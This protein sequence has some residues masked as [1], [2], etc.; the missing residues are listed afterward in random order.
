[1]NTY[2]SNVDIFNQ[3]LTLPERVFR[4]VNRC[5]IPPT[6]LGSLQFQYHPKTIVID[7]V[8]ILHKALFLRLENCQ[9]AQQ[10][11]EIFMNYMAVHFRLYQLEDAGWDKDNAQHRSKVDY[12]RML[13]GWL[14]DTNSREGAVLKCWV[15]SRFGLV[16]RFHHE[17]LKQEE[18]YHSFQQLGAQGLYGT[19]ALEAQLD[20]LY[21]YCQ[22][23]LA[24]RFTDNDSLC[25]YRG[26][27]HVDFYEVLKQTDANHATILLNNLNSFSS[28]LERADEFG[29][30][31]LSCQV[32]WQ[33]IL[34]YSNLLPGLLAGENEHLVIGGVYDIV[35]TQVFP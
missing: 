35:I 23:E 5:N 28:D 8:H 26:I 24:K 10:R 15:E 33:K 18:Q 3:E 32:P 29:D 16:T 34:F 31:I 6:V 14:F 11:A 27:N 25:L 12:R 17:S 13:R 9:Q 7:G 1:M 19:N 22:Y 30:Q 20:L 4:P 2:K 21:S